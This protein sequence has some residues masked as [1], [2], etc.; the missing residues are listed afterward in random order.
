MM[1]LGNLYVLW[2]PVIPSLIELKNII[3]WVSQFIN[4]GFSFDIMKNNGENISNNMS[5]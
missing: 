2:T 5:I 1:I 3:L 4:R